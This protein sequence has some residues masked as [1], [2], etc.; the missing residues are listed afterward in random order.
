MPGQQSIQRNKETEFK[1]SDK[2][3]RSRRLTM[4]RERK[5]LNC[6][7][8]FSLS[9]LCRLE[10][11]DEFLLLVVLRNFLL[12]AVW[13]QVRHAGVRGLFNLC[14]GLTVQTKLLRHVKKKD[15]DQ[16]DSFTHHSMCNHD[17]F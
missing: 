6:K 9:G 13:D 7:K 8:K 12:D 5:T 1:K 17:V 11:K 10:D 3:R 2:E 15:V 16:G 14:V 4:F